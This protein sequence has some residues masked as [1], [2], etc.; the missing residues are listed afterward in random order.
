MGIGFGNLK[1]KGY[2]D[3]L[4]ISEV[5]HQIATILARKPNLFKISFWT[6]PILPPEIAWYPVATSPQ[7]P[8]THPSAPCARILIP[9]PLNGKETEGFIPPRNQ[10]P[11]IPFMVNQIRAQGLKSGRRTFTHIQRRRPSMWENCSGIGSKKEGSK[12]GKHPFWISFPQ[13]H[14]HFYLQIHVSIGNRCGKDAA[15][16]QQFHG[17]SDLCGT[18]C[19]GYGPP[20][21]LAKGV[22]ATQAYIKKN[23]G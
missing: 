4:L 22:R 5:L 9:W 17:Q 13:R 2:G 21:T 12:A 10:T 8:M 18:W 7:I 3:P 19:I 23:W 6:I 14:P 1:I 11:M 16:V 15:F 20:G